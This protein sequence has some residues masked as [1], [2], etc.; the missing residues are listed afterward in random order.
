MKN[1]LVISSEPYL[2]KFNPLFSIYVL[3]QVK[4]LNDLNFNVNV[5]LLS[6]MPLSQ[7]ILPNRSYKFDDKLINEKN[8]VFSAMKK[9]Y[10]PLRVW[11]TKNNFDSLINYGLKRFRVYISNNGLPDLIHAHN[12]FYAGALAK[13]IK[14]IYNIPYMVTEH[15]SMFYQNISQYQKSFLDEIYLNSDI[16]SCVSL[17]LKNRVLANINTEIEDKD[18]VILPNAIDPLFDE[19]DALNLDRNHSKLFS[20]INIGNLVDVKNH[21]LLIEGFNEVFKINPNIRL[22][23]IGHGPLHK[24]LVNKV[25]KLNLE[26]QIIFLGYRDKNFIKNELLKSDAFILSSRFETF[27][28]VVAEALACGLPVIT[29]PCQGP[30]MLINDT[31]GIIIQEH[32]QKLLAKAMQSL[33]NNDIN[34]DKSKIRQDCIESFGQKAFKIKILELYSKILKN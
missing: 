16:F 25:K 24:K 4:L 21:E 15:S 8:K 10:T 19:I 23:I 26:N 31:N 27:G 33:F 11:S 2:P 20:F 3:D 17:A 13:E 9:Q 30:N 28:I 12:C 14:K 1:V 32:D 18:I 5:F 34:Y 29:T 6:Y 22:K 7:I